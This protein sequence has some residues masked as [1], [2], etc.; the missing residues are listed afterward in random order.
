MDYYLRPIITGKHRPDKNYRAGAAILKVYKILAEEDA[1]A[2]TKMPDSKDALLRW[3]ASLRNIAAMVRNH[4]ESDL[5]AY[6]SNLSQRNV[7]TVKPK[8]NDKSKIRSRKRA[9]SHFSLQ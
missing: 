1:M 8:S 6:V 7:A 3:N 4:T 9:L 2:L 5:Q